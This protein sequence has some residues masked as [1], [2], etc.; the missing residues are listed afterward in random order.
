VGR[1]RGQGWGPVQMGG[2]GPPTVWLPAVCRTVSCVLST[3]CFTS[4]CTLTNTLS[5]MFYSQS[6]LSKKGPLGHI[7]MMA[8]MERKVTKAKIAEMDI[9]ACVGTWQR[10]WEKLPAPP[11]PTYP[12][13]RY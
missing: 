6:L 4:V 7:W 1:V 3:L 12:S 13:A 9:K 8:H 2:R 11:C 5:Q 10:P